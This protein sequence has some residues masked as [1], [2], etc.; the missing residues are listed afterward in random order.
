MLLLAPRESK[1]PAGILPRNLEEEGF[2][3]GNAPPVSRSSLSRME[4]RIIASDP[5]VRLFL[6]HF[7]VM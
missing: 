2:Y 5:G 1:V 3:V 6:N 7:F 4:N